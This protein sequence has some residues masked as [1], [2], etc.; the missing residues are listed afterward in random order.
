MNYKENIRL[1]KLIL[2]SEFNLK[3]QPTIRTR[4]R[5]TLDGDDCFGLY[6]GDDI[7]GKFTH[8]ILISKRENISEKTLFNTIA[9]EYVHCWQLENGYDTLH[10]KKTMFKAWQEFF[11]EFYQI[12][13]VG[14]E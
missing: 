3:C 14:L 6:F 11:I 10:D 2:K 13:I 8:Q 9:H 1:F 7:N 12:D 4:K 5:L